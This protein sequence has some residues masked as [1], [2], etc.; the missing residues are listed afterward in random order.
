[1]APPLHICSPLGQCTSEY[2]C[3][4]VCVL[5]RKCTHSFLHCCICHQYSWVRPHYRPEK[6]QPNVCQ[7]L[8]TSFAVVYST[9]SV[10]KMTPRL[11][12]KFQHEKGFT[13]G[14]TLN[15]FKLILRLK[16]KK[17]GFPTSTNYIFLLPG[18]FKTKGYLSVLR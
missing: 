16:D 1:M 18:Q 8:K 9:V 11:S 10:S 5:N 6:K 3:R 2:T 15:F 12:Q 4:H 13:V 7:K 14:T 17:K